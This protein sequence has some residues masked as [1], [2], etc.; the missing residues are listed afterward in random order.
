LKTWPVGAA[1]RIAV[2]T[3]VAPRQVR[4][5]N[6]N[7]HDNQGGNG[8]HEIQTVEEKS[9]AADV[10][11]IFSLVRMVRRSRP[12]WHSNRRDR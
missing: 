8:W 6:D 1:Q 4:R 7:G 10:S 9:R 5:N 11:L 12:L 2:R 3:A